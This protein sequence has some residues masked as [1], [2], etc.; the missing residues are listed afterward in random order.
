MNRGMRLWPAAGVVALAFTCSEPPWDYPARLGPESA[1]K[2]LV[3]VS[4]SS[5]QT[6]FRNENGELDGLEFAIIRHL[7]QSLGLKLEWRL[8]GNEQEVWRQVRQ[9]R[10]HLTIMPTP[11][12]PDGTQ[13]VKLSRFANFSVVCSSRRSERLPDIPLRVSRSSLEHR[14][15]S[16]W[17]KEN[18]QVKLNLEVVGG[19]SSELLLATA[20]SEQHCAISELDALAVHQ[21]FL[22]ELQ[23]VHRFREKVE[24]A[25]QVA[26]AFSNLVPKLEN[27]YQK[28]VRHGDLAKLQRHHRRDIEKFNVFE[29]RIFVER[30]KTRL[31]LFEKYYRQAEEL[32]G[33]PWQLIAAI[34]YQESHWDISAKSFTGVEGLMMLTERTAREMGVKNR[35]DP[36][37]A[38]PAGALYL[39]KL[40]S[41]LPAY[42]QGDDRLAMALASYNVGYGHLQDARV[43]AI[44]KD[45]N[46]NNWKDL[47]EVLPLLSS[48]RH[49]RYLNHG[50]ARGHEPVHFVQRIH[51]YWNLLESR[52]PNLDSQPPLYTAAN[53]DF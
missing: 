8:V 32:T 53:F 11:A 16:Q 17:Q 27:A 39:K 19:S 47:Q 25:W 5:P 7:A 6:V 43:L 22:P 9:D 13:P 42:I 14:F 30:M 34:S 24:L 1:N 29:A 3:V 40:Y 2:K 31:P 26:P 20:Q 12:E 23:S 21:T 33:F 50:L 15:I 48:P 35:K 52:R 44:A 18:P 49:L 41:R 38:I 37:E 36:A 10:A 51:F 46:P 45:K 4:T 28:A